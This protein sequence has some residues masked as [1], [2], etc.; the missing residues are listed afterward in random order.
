MP[1]EVEQKY[2]VADPEQI[3]QK[4]SKLGGI[5]AGTVLQVDTYYAH[6][7]RD[8]AATDEALRIRRVG[9]QNFITY[10]GPKLD[11]TTK[12]RR[13]IEFDF[14]AG[15]SGAKSCDQLL[16]AL[17]FK[18]VSEVSKSRQ[19]SHLERGLH[20][21]ELAADNVQNV[22][23]FVELEIA[24]DQESELDEARTALATLAAE[25]GLTNVER[26]GYLELLLQ[27]QQ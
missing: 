8:F 16:Q 14:A 20:K 27:K 26:R 4:F 18:Q 13:E 21:I 23:T 6:P 22:G 12:T 15:D 24:V 2:R 11:A 25:L 1:Y 19:I 5:E 9:D 17:G 10:K 3:R 7:T